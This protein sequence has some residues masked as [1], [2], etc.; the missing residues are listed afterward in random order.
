MRVALISWTVCSLLAL[1][2]LGRPAPVA[3][4][5]QPAGAG[6]AEIEG[7]LALA[8]TL[9]PPVA[10]PR[11]TVTLELVL[12]NRQAR[13]AAPEIEV[14]L[15]TNLS[16][17][18][19]RAP[20]GT[21][22]DY[23]DNSFRWLPV[24]AADGGSQRLQLSF[25]ASVADLTRPE[26]TVEVIMRH[27]GEERSA[28]VAYWV[29]LPPQGAISAHP[30]VASVGQT[31]QL[32]A[33]PSGPGPFAQ[34]WD[35]GDGR[36][37][38][39][40]NPDVVFPAAGRYKVSLQ[41]ANPLAVTTA[42]TIVTVTPDPAASF[43]LA[44]AK[45]AAG[46][47]LAFVNESGGEP[48]LSFTW[49]FGDGATSSE[50]NPSHTFAEPGEYLVSLT[51]ESD[52]GTAETSAP[53]TVG[54]APTADVVLDEEGE[55][56][57]AV[58]GQAFVDE[59]VTNLHWE[60]GD[61][62]T[63]SGATISH[64]YRRAG[65]YPVTLTA[66]N[67]FGDTQVTRWIHI[68]GGRYYTYA[69]MFVGGNR[70]AGSPVPVAE[71]PAAPTTEVEETSTPATP[72]PTA[73]APAVVVEEIT[74]ETPAPAEEPAPVEDGPVEA[75]PVPADV[76]GAASEPVTTTVETVALPPQD[77]L[78]G[79]ATPAE[80]LLWYVNEARR[81]HGL[82]PLVYSYELSIA[83]QLHTVDMAQNSE[84]MHEGSDGSQPAERQQR[85]GYRGIYGGEAVAWGWESPVPVVEFW[86]NSP[87][88]RAL[89][90]N[91]NARE[92]GVGFTADGTAPNL[93]YWAAEFGIRLEEGPAAQ[94]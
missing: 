89:I 79:D 7:P 94:E 42:T 38:T 26:R 3:A 36:T 9:S 27:D 59:T 33:H 78:P 51:V 48:P 22:F 67:E 41:L 87:P 25:T 71:A 52:Y 37:V 16:F 39:A 43:S 32:E 12:T 17:A 85:Y 20:A 13:A 18:Q 80:Q 74:A 19:G 5:Q 73:T 23:Q 60:M 83:A 6:H 47:A 72:V 1:V 54:A 93:W 49:R 77:P 44:D 91:P 30:P 84:I 57:A 92:V 35:L 15:P 64:I 55:T 28:G 2:I 70:M 58:N 53:V 68:E 29:G 88:H 86:V 40:N 62:Q 45:P 4:A 56:G 75:E 61:G 8:I 76:G 31:V 65:D 50:R 34:T 90:L 81:L 10:A 82:P 66:S 14:S 11:D 69:P 46:E 63:Y 24:A 21:T